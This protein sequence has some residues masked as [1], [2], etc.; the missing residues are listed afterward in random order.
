MTT[1]YDA[2][3]KAIQ[4]FGH[5]I[6]TERKIVNILSDY[7]AFATLSTT[8]TV[9]KNMVE[10]GY[11]QKICDL[12]KKRSLFLWTSSHSLHRPKGVGCSKSIKKICTKLA[13]F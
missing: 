7:G 1:L 10:G 5:E 8:K 6:L 3:K 11:C 12:G 4:L 13:R 2:I 9:L